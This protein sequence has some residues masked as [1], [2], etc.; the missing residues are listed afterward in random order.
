VTGADPQVQ[1]V[2]E[3]SRAA[4]FQIIH[5]FGNGRRS[6]ASEPIAKS[7]EWNCSKKRRR[8]TQREF[9]V[10]YFLIIIIIIIIIIHG[11]ICSVFVSLMTDN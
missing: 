5:A 4:Y 3:G 6:Y 1:R 8:P 10:T 11:D 7:V 2:N 9:Q